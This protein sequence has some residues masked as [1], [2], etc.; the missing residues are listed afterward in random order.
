V[1]P[2]TFAEEPALIKDA[3]DFVWV[4]GGENDAR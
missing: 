4:A 1:P 2:L 3:A